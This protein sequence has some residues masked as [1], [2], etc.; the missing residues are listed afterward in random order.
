MAY[1][2]ENVNKFSKQKVAKNVAISLGYFFGLFH[3]FKK[4]ELSSKS[5]PIGKELPNLVTLAI[6]LKTFFNIEALGK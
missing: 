4:S 1:L 5:S 2:G 3:L 6:D